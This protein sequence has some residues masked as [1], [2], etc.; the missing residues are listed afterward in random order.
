MYKRRG[1]DFEV[2]CREAHEHVVDVLRCLESRNERAPLAPHCR[3]S[4]GETP[5]CLFSA[6]RLAT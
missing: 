1:P 4:A 2:I 3:F 6:F 5:K